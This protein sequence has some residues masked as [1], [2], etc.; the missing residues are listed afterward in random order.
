MGA[1]DGA[2]NTILNN[3]LS[4]ETT[5]VQQLQSLQGSSKSSSDTSTTTTTTAAA[6]QSQNEVVVSR[7]DQVVKQTVAQAEN[8]KIVYESQQNILD[9]FETLRAKVDAIHDATNRLATGNHSVTSV[10][11]AVVSAGAVAVPTSTPA[12]DRESLQRTLAD[13][14]YYGQ[15][16]SSLQPPPVQAAALSALAGPPPAHAMPS[17][18]NYSQQNLSMT[19]AQNTHTH[20]PLPGANSAGSGGKPRGWSRSTVRFDEKLIADATGMGYPRER[21][22]EVLHDIYESGQPANDIN[23]VIERLG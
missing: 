3:Q 15:Q 10:Q 19:M 23:L 18:P 9:E 12:M 8:I 5:L 20:T 13:A 22:L 2:M 14:G 1:L 7:L 16:S 17:A 4:L 11:P 6:S 21:V